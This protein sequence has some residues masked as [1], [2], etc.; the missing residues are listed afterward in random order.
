MTYL[1]F[2]MSGAVSLLRGLG[3][4]AVIKKRMLKGAMVDADET[5]CV[6]NNQ[7]VRRTYRTVYRVKY[8]YQVKSW[9]GAYG[10][11]VYKSGWMV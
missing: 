8:Q 10:T 11:G 7:V 9:S 1:L 4:G 5:A 6:G 2:G 3:N